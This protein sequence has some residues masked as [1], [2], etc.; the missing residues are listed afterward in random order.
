MQ[1]TLAPALMIAQISLS[2]TPGSTVVDNTLPASTLQFHHQV[3][4]DG[5]VHSTYNIVGTPNGSQN[6][7]KNQAI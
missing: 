7:D 4:A 2:P 5:S 1:Q 3:T 6:F